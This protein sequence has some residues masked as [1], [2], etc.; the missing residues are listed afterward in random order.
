MEFGSVGALK[1][2]MEIGDALLVSLSVGW[3]EIETA[4]PSAKRRFDGFDGFDGFGGF[5]FSGIRENSFRGSGAFEPKSRVASGTETQAANATLARLGRNSNSP[6]AKLDV[7][8]LAETQ[9][10]LKDTTYRKR[11]D[12]FEREQEHAALFAGFR[13]HRSQNREQ[14]DER[15]GHAREPSGNDAVV[16]DEVHGSCGGYSLSLRHRKI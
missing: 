16:P 14:R 11:R 7:R 9:R 5:G 6:A 8:S 13:E 2:D 4:M 15:Q 3:F 1:R 12:E 10:G